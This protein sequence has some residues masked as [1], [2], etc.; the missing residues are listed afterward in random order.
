MADKKETKV[1]EKEMTVADLRKMAHDYHVPM[2][3][4]TLEQIAKG[5]LTPEKAKA[6]EEHMKVTAQGLYPTMAKQINAGIPTAYLLD[7]YRQIAKQT[8]GEH[9]EPNF[10]TDPKATA[11]LH[12]GSDPSTGR[13]APMSLDQWKTHLMTHP[14]WEYD[15]TPAAHARANEIIEALHKGLAGGK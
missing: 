10:H 11:A 8:L 1:A 15:K 14:G 2:S 4:G 6:F 3:E 13:A 5:G 9:V 7:P 12:G